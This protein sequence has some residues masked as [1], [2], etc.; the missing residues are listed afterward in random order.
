ML[1]AAFLTVCLVLALP[2]TNAQAANVTVDDTDSSI[3]WVGNWSQ[4]PPGFG[5]PFNGT[6]RTAKDD[7][8]AYAEFKFTG[9]AVY[10]VSSRWPYEASTRLTLNPG[11]PDAQPL[12]LRLEDYTTQTANK[13]F[14]LAMVLAGATGLENTEHTVRV[15]A[16]P[17]EIYAV[18][19]AFIYTSDV[20]PNAPDS[21]APQTPSSSGAF[22]SF[23]TP[24]SVPTDLLPGS[25]SNSNSVSGSGSSGSG[26]TPTPISSSAKNSPPNLAIIFGPICGAVVLVT[27]VAAYFMWRFKRHAAR[28][29]SAASAILGHRRADSS[30]PNM[31]EKEMQTP[32]SA[33]YALRLKP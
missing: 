15:D 7:P 14:G 27:L 29:Q 21:H 13:E 24:L 19:D 5:K 32:S 10:F 11:S 2:S 20:D 1:F 6:Y 28:G 31:E 18:F 30:S 16:G 17:N 33:V 26:T 9:V 3:T 8:T 23:P 22:T 12:L 25:N 4:T